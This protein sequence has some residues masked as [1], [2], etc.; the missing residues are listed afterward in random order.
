V[1]VAP[2]TRRVNRGRGHSYLLDGAPVPGVTT[3]LGQGMPKPALIDRRV[4][5]DLEAG[6]AA[7]IYIEKL[8]DLDALADGILRAGLVDLPKAELGEG[9]EAG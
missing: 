7:R 8:A 2:A 6:A 5:I 3:I 1:T 4:V 9:G